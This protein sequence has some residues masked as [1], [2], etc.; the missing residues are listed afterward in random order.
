MCGWAAPVIQPVCCSCSLADEGLQLV[1]NQPPAAPCPPADG[2]R[3]VGSGV[4]VP[5]TYAWGESTV[6]TLQTFGILLS[7]LK[8]VRLGKMHHAYSW[9]I[10][11]VSR[12]ATTLL[13]RPASHGSPTLPS[14]CL[15]VLFA[16]IINA[17]GAV[18]S[19]PQ[20]RG[21][22]EGVHPGR[23]Q[24]GISSCPP[25]LRWT[26]ARPTALAAITH[27]CLVLP[28]GLYLPCRSWLWSWCRCYT[29]STCACACPS[30]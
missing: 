13:C 11:Q 1:E 15:Q 29:W 9:E 26:C 30:A 5:A 17:V 18:N 16:L 28:S 21:R 7:V 24:C 12:L 14:R 27:L 8:M 2:E 6:Q 19:V 23:M 20:V 4:L 22:K 10:T 3:H 25:P